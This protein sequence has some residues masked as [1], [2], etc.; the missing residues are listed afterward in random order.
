MGSPL[1]RTSD[2]IAKYSIDK[3]DSSQPQELLSFVLEQAMLSTNATGAAIALSD[4]KELVC[5]AAQGTA[6]DVGVRLN[7]RLGF[8]GL[9]VQKSRVLLCDDAERDPRVDRIACRQLGVRSI[10][11]VPLLNRGK[12]V[13]VLEV[14][15]RIAHAF[16]DNDIR[17]L[18][19]VARMTIVGLAGVRPTPTER[20]AVAL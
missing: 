19:L 14:L 7:L 10:I 16:D 15:S 12:L 4:G 5:W 18:G 11:A 13:G 9:C 2:S 17:Q 8:S 20:R 6:P 3:S 1:Q